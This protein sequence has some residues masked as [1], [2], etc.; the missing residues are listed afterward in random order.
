VRD[1]QDDPAKRE[2]PEHGPASQPHAP[3]MDRA[4]ARLRSSASP[5]SRRDK[6]R[7]AAALFGDEPGD[8]PEDQPGDEFGDEPKSDPRSA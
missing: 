6:H 8:E 7:V 5:K 1:P 4:F 2:Q 3:Q